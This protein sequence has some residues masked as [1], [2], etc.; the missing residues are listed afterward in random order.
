MLEGTAESS[1]GPGGKGGWSTK[2]DD[3]LKKMFKGK[4]RIA[5]YD[6]KGSNERFI[7]KDE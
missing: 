5:S 2:T 4:L 3:F 1:L 6:I 7:S